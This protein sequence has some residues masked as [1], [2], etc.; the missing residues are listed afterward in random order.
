MKKNIRMLVGVIAHPFKALIFKIS[1]QRYKYTNL[2]RNARNR[3]YMKASERQVFLASLTGTPIH[4][5]Y[6]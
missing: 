1:G 4:E 2:E 6:I 3:A 5:K